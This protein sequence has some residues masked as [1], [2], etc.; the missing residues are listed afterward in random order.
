MMGKLICFEGIDGSGK[1]SQVKLLSKYLAEKN[2][3][4]EVINFPRYEQNEYGKLIKRYLEGEFGKVSPYLIAPIFA[5]DRLLA[6]PE[7]ESWLRD[8]KVVIANRYVSSSKAH[9]CANLPEGEKE[10]FMEWIERL[11]YQT[12]GMPKPDLTILLKIDPKIGQGNA[13]KDQL[14]DIHEEN[15][16]HE[17]KA[18]KIYFELSQA[19]ENWQQIDCMEDGQMRSKEEINEQLVA[20]L[21]DKIF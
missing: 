20:I 4:Y 3:P 11:E 10:E 19:E 9:L 8:G 12:N 2:I 6:K 21:K 5:G 15:L 14:K 18:A 13:L 7:I 1:T 16:S 17:E